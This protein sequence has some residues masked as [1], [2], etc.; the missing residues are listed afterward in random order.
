[1][2]DAGELEGNCELVGRLA[3]QIDPLRAPHQ[4]ECQLGVALA[5]ASAPKD[6]VQ[7]RVIGRDCATGCSRVGRLGVVDVAN[8]LLLGDQLQPVLDT[9]KR[10]KR[11]GDLLIRYADRARDRGGRRCVLAVVSARHQRLRRQLVVRAELDPGCV[12]RDVAETAGEDSGVTGLLV[13]E[14]P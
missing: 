11:F 4:V 6:H 12:A 14:D 10:A 3:D 7:R 9:G 13:L 2:V 1:V 5:L 8:A